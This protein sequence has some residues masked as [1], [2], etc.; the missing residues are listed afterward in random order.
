MGFFSFL[1]TDTNESIRAQ[2]TCD[3]FLLKSTGN[4]AHATYY[5]GYGNFTTD[6][7]I[8]N[9]FHWLS[10]TNLKS[11]HLA[12]LSDDELTTIGIL[13][14]PDCGYYLMDE[15]GVVYVCQ[16]HWSKTAIEALLEGK[17]VHGF[18]TYA[19]DIVI[20]G[21]TASVNCHESAGRLTRHEYTPK[22][23]LKIARSRRS[24]DACLPSTS[25]PH[26]GF[27]YD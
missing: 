18:D 12:T 13:M 15:K 14:S 21:V 16:L 6:Q 1:T 7:G 11:C 3:V 10:L 23:P 2:D 22:H 19:A 24:Y 17:E 26:Q 8:V 4:H 5:D 27:F 20:D 25:C 9:V